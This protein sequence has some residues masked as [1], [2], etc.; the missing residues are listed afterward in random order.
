MKLFPSL[1]RRKPSFRKSPAAR[2]YHRC[3]E[4]LEPRQMLSRANLF[5]EYQGSINRGE[6][7]DRIAVTLDPQHVSLGD[8]PAYLSFH[9]EA[10]SNSPVDPAAL[11]IR[12][13]TGKLIAPSFSRHD[14]AGSKASLVLAQLAK[15]SYALVV[16]GQNNAKGVYRISVGLVGDVD[17]NHQVDTADAD[18]I[19]GAYGAK[20]GTSKYL[21]AADADMDGR[22]TAFD[23]SQWRLNSS[24]TAQTAS[25]SSAAFGNAAELA[26]GGAYDR[27]A[28]LTPAAGYKSDAP[29]K[30]YES[31]VGWV[32]PLATPTNIASGVVQVPGG[33]SAAAQM[34]GEGEQAAAALPPIEIEGTS[35]DWV[36]LHFKWDTR[37]ADYNNALG[38]YETNEDGEVGGIAPDEPGYQAAALSAGQQVF[39]SAQTAGATTLTS[40]AAG[41]Y[42]AFYMLQ[43]GGPNVW[44]SIHVAN[45]DDGYAHFQ[46]A[47]E[48]KYKIEDLSNNTAIAPNPGGR[49]DNDADFNDMVFTVKIITMDLDTDSDNTGAIDGTEAED[50]IETTFPGKRVFVNNDDDNKN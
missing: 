44:F 23:L 15:G 20:Q 33:R 45:K 26:L 41:T 47:G 8:K 22:I 5:A 2:R 46:T 18:L 4:G 14:V 17:G 40:V 30:F 50:E 36:G 3:F 43:D 27:I 25:T 28:A 1:R 49:L 42:I 24:N 16:H 7:E 29:M 10:G 6:A 48:N 39:S 38:F 34:S 11:R 32:Q 13:S 9:V 35:N 21:A 37:H 31:T 19:R 12:D